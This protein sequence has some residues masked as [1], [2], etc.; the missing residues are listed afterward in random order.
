MKLADHVEHIRKLIDTAFR[1]RLGRM[2]IT[3]AA[4][5]PIDA[6][7]A[8]YRADRKRI[9]TI[10]EVWIA[11]TGT[12][13]EAYEKLVEE[14]TFTLF[15]RLAALKVMEAHTLHPEIVTRRSQHGDRSFAHKHW[16][17]QNPEGRNDEME[18]L[19]HFMEDQLVAL[20]ADIPLFSPQH[21]YHLLPTAIELNG[22]MLAFNQVEN[23]EQVEPNIWQ[24]D[25]VLGWLYESYSNYKKTAH[26]ESGDKTEYNKVSIQSQ[27]YTP[28]WV[29]KFLVDN[30][31]GKLYL[32]M[33]PDSDI[34]NGYKI[35]NAPKT[36]T[37]APKPLT[38]IKLIDPATGSGNFLL[39]GFDLFYDLYVDQIENYGADY[40]DR[41]IPE[42][43][44]TH[45]LHGVDLDDRAIQLAQLGLYIK[46][47]RKKRSAKIEHFNI[48]SSD[49]YLPEYTEVKHLF[50]SDQPLSPEL[51]KI[52]T[53]LWADLQQAYKFGALIRLEEKFSMRLHGLVDRETKGVTLFTETTLANYENFR[54]NFFTNLQKAVAQNTAKQG[55]TFLNTKTQDA[56]TFLQLLTQKYDVAVANPPYTDSADFGTELKRFVE[57]NYK[58]PYKF[59]SNLYATFIKRCYELIDEKGKMALIHP[60]TFMYIKTFEDVRKFMLNSAHI[61]VFVDYGLSN[62]FGTVMV[63]PAFYVLEKEKKDEAS[64]FISLDQYT[65]TPNEKFKKDF[66]LEALDDFVANRPNKHNITLPQEKLK[67]IEGWPFI[68]WISD[69]FR[70]KFK[71]DSLSDK[72]NIAQG[73]ATANNE[74]FVRL[75]WEVQN[76]KESQKWYN[77]AK[78]GPYNKWHGNNWS[79][80]NWENNGS[81]IRSI[82]NENG[83]VRSRTQNEKFYFKEGVT[84]TASGS[85]GAS[86]RVHEPNSLFDVGGSCI[87]PTKDYN[88]IN[89][90]LALLNAKLSFYILDCLN[91][92][93]NTQVGD[94]QRIPFVKP[95]Q[96]L[97]DNI[98]ALAAEN[99]A[100]KKQLNS[101]RIIET[102]YHQNP[103]LAYADA[104]LKNR[105]LAYL[106]YENVQLT[107]VLLNEAVIN[108]LIF[109]V[110]KLSEEDRLQVEAKMGVPVGQL[111]IGKDELGMMNEAVEKGEVQLNPVVL[112][113]VRKLPVI[114]ISEEQKRLIVSEFPSLY[115][116]NNDLEEFCIRHQVNPINVWC[117]FKESKVL[118]QARAAEIALEFLADAFRS[119]L[120]ADEDGIVPLVGLPGEPRL[121]DRFEEYCFSKGFTSAQIMQLDGLLG[122]SVNEYVEQYFFRH[123]SDHLN[124][125][126]Y[127]P[128]TPF[129]WHLSSGEHQ[130]F[131]AY[132]IIYKW[133]RDSLYKLK[134][135]YLSKRTESLQYRLQQI[136]DSS[137]GQAQTEK[138][139]IRLQLQEIEAFS[140]KIDELIAAGYDP[141]LD[142]GVGKNIAPLQ[143]RGMLKA[144]VL[145]SAGKN[146][147]LQKYLNADW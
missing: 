50:E 73:I 63:D 83:K 80:V 132:I 78:G 11:E 29:V 135:T 53:D 146:S 84:Y 60:L 123:F 40:D 137:T 3:A 112:E 100:F 18:G 43:I 10:R 88:N 72:F 44:I 65:R 48:V 31:L 105:L 101:F 131:E 118:P 111:G 107:Q 91:P 134:S 15:N 86:F 64:W 33:Y 95:P 141:K 108:E 140:Q 25:D 51:E 69:G 117:W 54:Q 125:F 20:A 57:A 27:V 2:G 74:R 97:E 87:F 34:K 129:I 7:P 66:C 99:V 115:Q 93:V 142:D 79:V 47:K 138:E 128:K 77:Y 98:S 82:K 126:M 45:N 4:L 96:L 124:L 109:K 89:Y 114:E 106:N 85:K 9:E 81:E 143:V 120:M 30:S 36:R 144:E 46:A 58:Q 52:V 136:A 6:I 133:N 94:L 113:H 92:T 119:I 37:R 62:L 24:S 75:W 147:Q 26:K 49:F 39:Y 61:S 41:K 76:N 32:E 110:Y 16:L 67:I 116:S 70:E 102:N 130:G 5:Q 56:I 35:A 71:V 122:R 21:P 42:L 28:R 12:V 103:L 1:N 55:Q 19:V 8:E 23:D 22:I 68:Y 14:F 59:N 38:E 104:T 121:M 17:E 90:L 145:K 13:A 139:T 127:L